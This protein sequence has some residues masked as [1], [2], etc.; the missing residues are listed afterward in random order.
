MSIT[1]KY[2]ADNRKIHSNRTVSITNLGKVIIAN[3]RSVSATLHHINARSICNKITDFHKYVTEANPTLCAIMETWLSDD[4]QDLRFKRVP[5]T[6]YNIIS[7]QRTSGKKGGGL[8]IIYKSCLTVKELLGLTRPS[9]V[10]ELLEILV[11]FKESHATSTQYTIFLTQVSFSFVV[12]FQIYSN[13]TSV[14]TVVIYLS[15]VTSTYTWMM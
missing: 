3:N 13:I 12:N 10:M 11:N 14:R 1:K 6:G 8:A 15:S 5:P 7:K 9:E 2:E 4:E